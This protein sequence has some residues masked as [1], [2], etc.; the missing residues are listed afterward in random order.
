MSCVSSVTYL[1]TVLR[2]WAKISPHFVWSYG[3]WS[4]QL[5]VFL[6]ISRVNLEK[7]WRHVTGFLQNTCKVSRP[8]KHLLNTQK[9][10]WQNRANYGLT[11]CKLSEHCQKAPEAGRSSQDLDTVVNF[12][13]LPQ[14]M[15]S[16]S[17]VVENIF[18]RL[19]GLDSKIMV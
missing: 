14:S 13:A 7:T 17:R 11:P 8:S 3:I 2:H 9:L 16:G 19:S 15:K 18:N 5:F 6:W 4:A 1:E 10:S 12:E